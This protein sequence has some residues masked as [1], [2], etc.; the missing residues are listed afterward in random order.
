LAIRGERRP[1]RNPVELSIKALKKAVGDEKLTEERLIEIF[2]D[3]RR[4]EELDLRYHLDRDYTGEAYANA[5]IF[6][7]VDAQV[8]SFT[9]LTIE[10]VNY[11]TLKG[12]ASHF[13][14]KACIAK[15]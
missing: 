12:R 13:I 8:A 6:S 10:D 5:E 4:D 1:E 2:L 11:L 3:T 7:A 14:A 15:M 9:A